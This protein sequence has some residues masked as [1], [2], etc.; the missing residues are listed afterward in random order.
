MLQGRKYIPLT[1]GQEIKVAPGEQ[2]SWDYDNLSFRAATLQRLLI[3]T[4]YNQPP[5]RLRK[6]KR[7]DCLHP[8]F[9]ADRARR[10]YCSDLCA[11]WAQRA[12]KRKYWGNHGSDARRSKRAASKKRRR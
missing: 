1:L 6:C 5:A 12:V 11:N 2:F 7:P 8:Y 10:M 3:L 4:L 9:L